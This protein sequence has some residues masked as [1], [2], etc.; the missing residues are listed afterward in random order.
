MSSVRSE[1]NANIVRE[2]PENIKTL[3]TL[4]FL[5]E[6][7]NQLS[8]IYG[9]SIG[10]FAEDSIP[11]D[12]STTGWS[13]AFGKTCINT[14]NKKLYNYRETL[15]WY[16]YENFNDELVE[17]LIESGLILGDLSKVIEN[18]LGIK[19]DD[20]IE[21]SICGKFYIKDMV[22]V[23]SEEHEIYRC[24]HCNDIENTSN[25]N[26]DETD[27]HRNCIEEIK[28]HDWATFNFIVGQ[29]ISG[30]HEIVQKAIK[31]QPKMK[32]GLIGWIKGMEE[33]AGTNLYEKQEYLQISEEIEKEK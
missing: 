3:I 17:I 12:V 29:F 22:A 32:K 8:R 10:T 16:D 28:N 21:C 31:E 11:Y 14:N 27:Y 13:T 25:E 4:D 18:Q 20:L 1:D 19:E 2:I 9:Y 6:F 33:F 15:E 24:L 26:E 7:R 23:L 30:H 5:K